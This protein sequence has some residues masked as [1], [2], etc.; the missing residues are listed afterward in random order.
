MNKVN[1]TLPE[2]AWLNGGEHE[3]GGDP[4]IGRNLILHIRSASV[5]EILERDLT[6]LHNDVISYEFDY[7][8]SLGLEEK[9]VVALH[10]S[11]LLDAE[12]DYFQIMG[13]L[14]SCAK[15]YMD[16]CDWEDKN[17]VEEE[18]SKFN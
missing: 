15:W 3:N 18:I 7:M 1:L 6:E 17:I 16:Y 11:P 5:I 2:W 12:D 8:N 14:K 9:F 10:H 4:L 13:I